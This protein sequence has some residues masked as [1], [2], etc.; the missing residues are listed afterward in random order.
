[1]PQNPQ[2][3]FVKKTVYQDLQEVIDKKNGKSEQRLGE[4]IEFCE[5]G[6]LLKK[7]PYD[8]SGGEQQRAALAKILLC[9]PDILLLDEPTK[10]LD[11]HFKIKLAHMLKGL[12]KSGITIIMVSHDVEFC[13]KYAD[14]CGLFFDGS[15]VSENTARK[16]F[17]KNSFY[18]TAANR[19]SRGILDG[20]V[21]DE[22]VICAL[23][24]EIPKIDN[25]IKKIG[26]S[27]KSDKTIKE[28]KK[29]KKYSVKGMIAGV[30][31]ALCFFTL[32]VLENQGMEINKYVYQGLEIIFA[33]LSLACIVPQSEIGVEAVQVPKSDRKLRKRT[34]AA[35]A[36]ILLAIPLTIFTGV[37]YL[38]DRK[39][40][41]IS[42]LII[43][44]TMLPFGLIFEGR[45]P[46][47]RELVIISVMCAL[48]VAGRAAFYMLPEFKPVLAIVIISGICFGGETG[49]LVG[50]VTGFVSNF[51][52]GQGPWTPWQMFAFGIVGFLAGV[53]FRKGFLRKTKLSL[54][55]FGFLAAILI[56]GG[57]MNPA[58]VI[59]NQTNINIKM[60][61]SAYLMGLPFD[62][63]HAAATAF[64]LWFISEPMTE[65]LERVKVK[66]GLIEK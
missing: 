28:K 59:M 35:A 2:S 37:F 30:V 25:D 48:A 38:G 33:A 22:D 55:V 45:K 57:I 62:L 49:F 36:L 61:M 47:A 17:V 6:E 19:M 12:Q 40:Y 65:K 3:L 32:M 10:G 53:L 26:F 29:T 54:A 52:F 1:M 58:S 21:L 4:I 51:F 20:A 39:Y 31:F 14:R 16:F 41:F 42:L 43:L 46:Q 13:A 23:G 56:Y 18:T 34:I 24:G 9:E 64:F 15:I 60:F 27:Q 44:E 66:Y 11:A 5:L 8:L 63:I 7:H 50:A